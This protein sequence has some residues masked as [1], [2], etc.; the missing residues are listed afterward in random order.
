MSASR[1]AKDIVPH[2]ICS[3]RHQNVWSSSRPSMPYSDSAP[4]LKR[5][6]VFLA[7]RSGGSLEA[8]ELLPPRLGYAAA[9]PIF[10]MGHGPGQ[11]AL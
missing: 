8:G 5:L 3:P 4:S 7:T 9:A 1:A 11:G 10:R 6:A 2:R